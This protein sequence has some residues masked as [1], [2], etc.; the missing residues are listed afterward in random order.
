MIPHPTFYARREL[1]EKFGSYKLGYRVSA[2]FE[3][4]ARFFTKSV[5]MARYPAVMVKMRD[6][7]ISTTG[8]WWRVHQNLEIVRACKENGI[9]TNIFMVAMKIPFKLASYLKR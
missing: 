4:M 1:F 8:F 5:K 9:Y 2:D 6:G 7:G 3:L